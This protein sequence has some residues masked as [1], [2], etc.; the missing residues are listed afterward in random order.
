[1][2]TFQP[3]DGARFFYRADFSADPFANISF[4]DREQ[5]EILFHLSLRADEGLAVCNRRGSGA[6]DWSRERPRKVQLPRDGVQVEIRF[7]PPEV[8]VHLDGG[9]L[10]RFSSGPLRRAHFPDLHRI[11]YVDFQGGI[12]AGSVEIDDSG[13]RPREG[14]T[15]SDRLEIRGQVGLPEAE[16]RDLRLEV[17]GGALA[18]AVIARPRPAGPG[19]GAATDLRAILPGRVWEAVPGDAA[20]ELQLRRAD[21]R[22][23]GGALRITRDEIAARID[24]VLTRAELQGDALAAMQVAEHVRF[25]GLETRLSPRARA[26]LAGVAEFYGLH[27]FL[28][29]GAGA[30]AALE[31]VVPEDLVARAAPDPGEEAVRQAHAR[32]TETLRADPGADP[33]ALLRDTDLPP[34]GRRLLLLMFSEYF[35]TRDAFAGLFALAEE[36]GLADFAPRGEPWHDSAILPFLWMKGEI[37]GVRELLWNLGEPSGGWVVT[38]AVAW[39]IRAAL[40]APHLA[41]TDR[42]DLVYGFTG[43]VDRRAGDYWGRT[44]CLALTRATVHLLAAR[45]RLTDHLQRHVC[46]CALRSYGL[47][48]QFWEA[49]DEAVAAGR[50]WLSADLHAAREAF[51]VIRG[52]AGPP[53]AGNGAAAREALAAALTLF[54]RAGNPDAPRLRRELLGPAGIAASPD[55]APTP[56]ALRLAGVAPGEAALRHMAFPG[57]PEGGAALAREAAEAMAEGYAEVPRAPYYRLQH[58]VSRRVVSLAARVAAPGQPP[59]DWEIDALAADLSVLAGPR[60]RFLGIG[61]G[62]GLINALVRFGAQEPAARLLE[63]I[64][65]MRAALPEDSLERLSWAPAVLSAFYGLRETARAGGPSLAGE[66]LTLFPECARHEPPLPPD[67]VARW[68]H[69]SPIL[70]TIVTVFSCRPNLDSRVAAMRAGWLSLLRTVGVPYVV[71][72]GDGDG[73]REGDVVHVAAPDD[74]EGLPQ[75]TLAAIRWVHDNTAF[76]YMLKIDDDCFLNPA[77][78]FHSLSYR[79]F[80]YYGRILTRRPGQ[81]DRAWHCQKATSARGRMEL[82]KSPEPSTYA[83]GGSGYTLSR[84]AMAAALAAADSPEGRQLIQVSFMEDKLLGDLLALRGIRPADEDYRISIRRRT[85]AGATPV[86]LWVNG[87]DASRAAPVKLVHL[88]AHAPQAAAME[89]LEGD[90]LTPKKIWPSYQPV[91][92]GYQSNALEMIGPQDRLERARTAPVAV[93]ACMRNEMFM[94]PHFL[95]HYRRLGVES[96]LIADNCSDDGTLEYLAEQPDV[97]L[98]SVDTDYRLSH[99]GVA[100]QQAL[101]SAFRVGRWSLVADA[102]E[103]LVWQD[104]PGGSLPDLLAGPDF[105]TAEAVRLF[106]LDMYPQGR[107]EEADFASGDPFA[108]AGFVDR[109]PFLTRWPGQGPYS[110][111]PTWTSALR[112]RLIPGSRADLFVA[113]KIALLRYQPWM[114]LSAGLHFLGDVKLSPRE[115]LFAHFK[116]NADFRR[117]AR[118]EVSRRQHFND[119]EEYRKYLALVSE[120]RDVIHDPEISVPW[121]DC[122]FVRARLSGSAG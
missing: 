24:R 50:L 70:D 39:V 73:R 108:E 28:N 114:R 63:H 11:G 86:S 84:R 13:A 40:D 49:V 34:A 54:E 25:A 37:G 61:L 101:L 89:L 111:M 78:F 65:Q 97:A 7:T 107:L 79:K 6:E 94:L 90:R 81:M 53:E 117:K 48:R 85:H 95:A 10:F 83:D 98:F 16:A 69:A 45:D 99:Y 18:C 91:T 30:A 118:A 26:A 38:P 47:S 43:F 59:A 96:F 15:L 112:H 42:E 88:D 106:M 55:A 77:E 35:C 67:G 33:V 23:C 109:V 72:V 93:V 121:R 82:D 71:I 62:L 116:Y 56:A 66:A 36:A 8:A 21:G 76:T 103:L 105:E 58:S 110:N 51:G 32:I 5:R 29:P 102:D 57:A 104:G 2:M 12:S 46:D 17:S 122:D 113:Q 31:A 1:M 75:K 120:G 14:L 20:L 74:Y 19:R 22:A 115:L 68:P 3:H 52:H 27:G 9:R 60:S 92:L 4:Y 100:W 80:D 44:P 64:A 119:A 87:F 41:G